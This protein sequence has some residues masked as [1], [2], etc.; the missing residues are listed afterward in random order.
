[1]FRTFVFFTAFLVNSAL[2]LA[3]CPLAKSNQTEPVQTELTSWP[4][5]IGPAASIKVSKMRCGSCAG[6]ISKRLL[7]IKG[8]KDV[9]FDI[10]GGLVFVTIGDKIQTSLVLDALAGLGYPAVA[11]TNG[12]AAS[13]VAGPEDAT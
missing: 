7:E 10:K 6:K 1:M 13:T 11:V 3:D 12:A 4:E 8:I 5:T 9:N 2:A